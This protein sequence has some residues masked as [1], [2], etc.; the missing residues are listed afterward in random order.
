M[1]VWV[2]VT[3]T[4]HYFTSTVV[5]K[6]VSFTYTTTATDPCVREIDRPKKYWL[7]GIPTWELQDDE[8]DD[9]D[10]D[11]EAEIK[12]PEDEIRR[13]RNEQYVNKKGKKQDIKARE[14]QNIKQGEDQDINAG[15]KQ[16][17]ET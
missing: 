1:T 15:D 13:E 12:Q 7:G 10:N 9:D 17:V 2:D 8:D 4:Q 3:S 11:E 16:R 5:E 14:E 6:E